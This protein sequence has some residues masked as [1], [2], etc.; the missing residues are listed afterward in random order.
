[1]VAVIEANDSPYEITN[2]MER[3]MGEYFSYL[4]ASSVASGVRMDEIL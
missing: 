3:K 2:V 4:A 1:M